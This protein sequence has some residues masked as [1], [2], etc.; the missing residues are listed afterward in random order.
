MTDV[1]VIVVEDDPMVRT[2][3]DMLLAAAD[4]FVLV[5][6]AR[7]GGEALALY[8]EMSPDVVLMDIQ[9]PVLD[10]IGATRQIIAFDPAARILTLTA[11]SSEE[12]VIPALRAGTAGYLLKD[13]SPQ[14]I[15]RAIMAVH[16]GE[17]VLSPA[18][19]RELIA[20][21]KAEEVAPVAPRP[22]PADHSLTPRELEV[23][24]QLAEG[25][26][27]REIGEA[28]YISE[29]TVKATLGRIMAKFQ[30]RDRVQVLIEG[31]R[32]GL[33]EVARGT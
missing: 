27:N 1:R 33:V 7:H 25:K 28:L 10:G 14:E 8:R 12:F 11:F 3:L 24:G 4:G 16:R 26:S 32:L 5:G 18:I 19:T 30:V 9:M 22:V 21:V 20:T 2:A 31:V 6:Q 17:A 13:S 29:A 23:L 15:L